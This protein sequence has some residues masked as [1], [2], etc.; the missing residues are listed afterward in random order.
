ML[1]K[2]NSET[3][4]PFLMPPTNVKTMKTFA[5]IGIT[6]LASCASAPEADETSTRLSQTPPPTEAKDWAQARGKVLRTFAFRALEKGLVE[7]ARGYLQEACDLDGRDQESHTTLARLYLAEGDARASL[8][9]AER[10]AAA[11]PENTEVTLVFAAAL[12]ENDRTVEANQVLEK[13]WSRL[14]HQANFARILVTHYAADAGIDAAQDFVQRL[15][16]ERPQ[17]ASVWAAAG[18]LYLA[19]GD[20]ESSADAYRQALALDSSLATPSALASR[21]GLKSRS[22]DPILAAALKA[23]GKNDYAGAERLLRFMYQTHPEKPAVVTALGR[24]LWRQNRF[25]E[26]ELI[27]AGIA[28]K[29]RNWQVALLEAKIAINGKKWEKALGSLLFARQMRPGTRATELLLA[30]VEAQ[31]AEVLG[32]KMP[33]DI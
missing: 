20:L 18:D 28:E 14:G 31:I 25:Q 29:D 26:A 12:A 4:S 33:K 7:E 16:K 11:H 23:E 6:F 15:L 22:N 1:R 21:L 32:Q 2:L 8:A 13:A 9:Y 27:L 3:L 30:H 24:V 10:A 19:D 5:L 17:D